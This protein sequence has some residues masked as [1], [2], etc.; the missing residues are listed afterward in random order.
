MRGIVSCRMSRSAWGRS[1]LV[2]RF[3]G[4]QE[5][6]PPDA[7]PEM[8]TGVL[9]T[10]RCVEQKRLAPDSLVNPVPKTCQMG[11]S[12]A[13]FFCHDVTDHCTLTGS[14]DSPLFVCCDH[15]TPPLLGSK[16]GLGSAG[17]RWSYADIFFG[18]WLALQT[19]LSFIS[20]VSLQVCRNPVSM[21]TT[22]P[23]SAEVQMFLAMK[24]LQ[25]TRTVV[26]RTNGYHG[27]AQSH[28]R[29]LRAVARAVGQW[30]S[31]M[32]RSLSWR[33]AV[34]GLS[35][36]LTPVSNSRERLVWSPESRGQLC[37]WSKEHLVESHVFSVVVGVFAGLTYAS[38]RMH[39]NR[40][41]RAGGE[42]S[43]RTR[44]KRSSRSLRAR[45]RALLAWTTM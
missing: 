21:S 37:A 43:E 12:W 16:Y 4:H 15:S 23:L 13:R 31:S 20:H 3:S 17:F 9:C 34:V 25:P 26:G 38:V 24:C 44:F 42:G 35:Q 29:S 10:A 2:C 1:E 27:F 22:Y 18:F 33:S 41:S 7:Y 32:V 39:R 5:F 30:S 6:V 11:F 19:A 45:S 40:A 36:F 14:A 8:V 28:G